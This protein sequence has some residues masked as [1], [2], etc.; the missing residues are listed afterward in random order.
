[1]DRYYMDVDATVKSHH[2][3]I[4]NHMNEDIQYNTQT[5]D[6]AFVFSL[7]RFLF[8]DD[9][10]KLAVSNGSGC[11]CPKKVNLAKGIEIFFI[12]AAALLHLMYSHFKC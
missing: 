11:L 2:V 6:R 8:T 9:E 5:G 3:K 10:L 7:L 4:L 1:M 12:D